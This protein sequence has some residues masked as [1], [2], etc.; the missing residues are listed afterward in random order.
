MTELTLTD[1]F[2][3]AGGSSTGASQVPGV[4][5]RVASNHW[6]LAVD[7]HNENHPDADHVC[8]DLS[9][10][11]P[12]YFPTTDIGWFS[13]ECTN[14]S[15]A[16]GKKRADSTPDL[17]GE[18]LPDA[19]AERSRATMWDVVRFT[20]VHRYRAVLVENV[21]DAWNWTPFRAWLMAMDSLGYHHEVVYLNSMHAQVHGPGRRSRGTACTSCSG[22]TGTVPRTCTVSR[23]RRRCVLS[24]GR[25]GR[26]SRGS[27]PT[28]HRGGGT[29][30]STCTAART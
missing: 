3:G 26:C 8:A 25:C 11:D 9:Q 12:R 20:E 24:A 17:F 19:A 2:C 22:S 10:I 21:V 7:T 30:R 13:P 4:T 28:G 15:I 16:K 14:H 29:G 18:V 23:A 6:K 27:A 5:V 1:L